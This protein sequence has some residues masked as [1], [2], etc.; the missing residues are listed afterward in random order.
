MPSLIQK[1]MSCRKQMS[2]STSKSGDGL[3]TLSFLTASAEKLTLLGDSVF[4]CLR[5]G[6][7]PGGTGD[8]HPTPDAGSA[9]ARGERKP[10]VL[11]A[12]KGCC[13]LLYFQLSTRFNGIPC[14]L[15]IISPSNHSGLSG[16]L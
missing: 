12:R 8:S 4:Q 11:T 16:V 6:Q 13:G 15:K 5:E 10:S 14:F 9:P 2:G 7:R 3:Q 1:Q